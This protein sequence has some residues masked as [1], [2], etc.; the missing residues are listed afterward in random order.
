MQFFVVFLMK[1]LLVAP[2]LCFGLV[3]M[4]FSW[5]VYLGEPFVATELSSISHADFDSKSQP[6]ASVF[7]KEY[8]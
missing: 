3:V 1:L 8:S 4:Y 5:N 2:Y 6:R 7:L